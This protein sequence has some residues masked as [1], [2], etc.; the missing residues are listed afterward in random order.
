MNDCLV[1]LEDVFN[2][3]TV[4]AKYKQNESQQALAEDKRTIDHKVA[5]L[6]TR[7]HCCAVS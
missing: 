7:W 1:I 6:I 3:D 5:L 4:Y 2:T